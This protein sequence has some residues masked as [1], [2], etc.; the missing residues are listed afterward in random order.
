MEA[1]HLRVHTPHSHLFGASSIEDLVEAARRGGV[2]ALAMTDRNGLYS[3]FEFQD[4]CECAGIQPLFGAH[5]GG[6]TLIARD[7]EGYR[8]LCFLISAHHLQPHHH[9]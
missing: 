7:E 4:A 8:N 5:F 1:V 9:G 2:R 3:P 6:Q